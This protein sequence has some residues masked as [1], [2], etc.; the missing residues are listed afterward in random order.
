MAK[1][2]LLLENLSLD[3]I[4]K[5]KQLA[6]DYQIVKEIT[7]NNKEDIEIVL[8]WN[9]PVK[10]LI[11]SDSSQVKWIQY[12]YA[13]VNH[14]PLDLF[15]RKNI[16]LTSGSGAN[17]GAVAESTMGAI[18]GISR[19]IIQAV[20]E[21]EK[22]NWFIPEEN[23]EL[24]NKNILIVGA[25]KIGEEIGRLAQAFQMNRIGINRSGRKINYMNEQYT[26][27]ELINQI[28]RGDFII[29]ILPV[30]DQTR[31]FF[32]EKL[33]SR[34]KK[35]AI[36]INVGRGETVLMEDLIDSLD[37]E[38]IAG[39]VLDVFEE[40]PLARN[41]PLWAYE[42]VLI[43][44]HIAGDVEDQLDHLFPIFID[45]LSAYLNENT[46]AHNEIDLERGY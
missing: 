45:N 28:H 38:K 21:Q 25:G 29:N 33:F 43:T 22:R 18:L 24:N 35:S 34:M 44:P 4:Q 41:H 9:E 19:N 15:K 10:E 13:G 2:I 37:K 42:N 32:D 16:Q 26:Q 36:F 46:L 20:K 5:L 12:V 7:E 17:A 40:E 39:A 1:N 14:L 23:M 6:P 8:G 3:K 31:D 30:T 27:G 11:E